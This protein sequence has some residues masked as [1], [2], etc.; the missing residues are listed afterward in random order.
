MG[1]PGGPSLYA[2]YAAD[3]PP[4]VEV[5]GWPCVGG[6]GAH[7]TVEVHY[8]GVSK[9][10]RQYDEHKPF[11]QTVDALIERVERDPAYRIATGR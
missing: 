4:A 11:P 5:V 8:N 10:Y 7:A 2:S 6:C 3:A 1:C 9:K